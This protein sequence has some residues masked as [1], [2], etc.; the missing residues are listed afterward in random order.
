MLL[1]NLIA[2]QLGVRDDGDGRLIFQDVALA[3]ESEKK[4]EIHEQQVIYVI[5]QIRLIFLGVA[6]AHKKVQRRVK[7]MSSQRRSSAHRQVQANVDTEI[8]SGC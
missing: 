5:K 6:Q 2:E 7:Y 4:S 1:S 3:K 8:Y